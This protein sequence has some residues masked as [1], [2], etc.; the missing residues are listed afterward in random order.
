[1]GSHLTRVADGTLYTR[2]GPEIGV[3]ATKTYVSQVT[4]MTLFAL[5]LAKLRGTVDP[6]RLAAIGENTKF[7]PLPST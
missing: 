2:G 7:C 3:A 6:K 4:A 1:M 5:Y